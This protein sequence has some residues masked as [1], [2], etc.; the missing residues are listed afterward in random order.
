MANLED[1]VRS[2]V[3]DFIKNEVLF[4][5]LDVSNAVKQALPHAKHR[6]VRDVVRAMFT[7]DIETQGWA[8][9]PISVTLADGSQADALLYHPLVDSWDL[10][11]K[12]DDQKRKSFAFRPAAAAQATLARAQAQAQTVPAPAPVPTVVPAPA[13]PAS[14]RSMWDNLFKTQPSIF[15]KK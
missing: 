1:T 15:P 8:R 7:T 9:T 13:A 14:A 5:A 10:D 3:Q 12:Y 2:V 6:E 11:A 4:T